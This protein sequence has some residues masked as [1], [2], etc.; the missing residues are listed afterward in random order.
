MKAQYILGKAVIITLAFCSQV[1]SAAATDG[2]EEDMVSI[3]TRKDHIPEESVNGV[4]D[5]YF[6][7]YI[8]SLIDMNYYEYKVIVVVKERDVWLYNLPKNALISKSI[9]SFVKDVPGVKDVHAVEGEPP[10]KKDRETARMERAVPRQI[11]GIWFPQTTVLFLPLVASPR[12]VVNSIGYRG[13]DRVMGK[14]AGAVSLGDVFPLFRWIDV[15]PWH[16]DLQFDI[17][18]GIWSVFN[19]DPHPDIAGGTELVNTDFYVGL[20]FTYAVNKWSWRFRVYHISSHLGDEFM[21]NHPGFDRKNPSFEAFD[22]YMSYQAYGWWRLYVGPGVI[23]HSDKSF[24]MKYWYVEYGTEMRFWGTKMYY[25]RLYGTFF[26]GAHFRT[27][28]RLKA[29]FDGTFVFGYEWSKLQGVG[30][31]IRLFAQ[32]HKG[33]SLEG[34][35]FRDRTQYGAILF[36]YGF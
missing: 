31:K 36:S 17:E 6:E 27:W 29:D 24:P 5:C 7:G 22:A 15:F 28:Q 8:Q 21:V 9:I 4:T 25:H 12:Q 19:F 20:P 33:F 32:Y 34:Q 23:L 3:L 14:K 2:Y 35:F 11:K 16:G 30:R 13:G 18:S 10:P 1:F 26:T